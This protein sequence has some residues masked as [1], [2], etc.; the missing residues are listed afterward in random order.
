ML[1]EKLEEILEAIWVGL[2][3]KKCTL[4]TVAQRCTVEFND[5]DLADLEELALITRDGDTLGLTE[6][7]NVLM[8]R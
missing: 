5:N 1:D 3:N 8:T 4:E 2:E 7:G 6:A